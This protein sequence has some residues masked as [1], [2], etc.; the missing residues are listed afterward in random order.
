MN[1]TLNPDVLR[2]ARNK[3]GLSEDALARKAGV[4]ADLV[5][6]TAQENVS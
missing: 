4:G 6:Q 2:W 1:A 3:A 5:Q